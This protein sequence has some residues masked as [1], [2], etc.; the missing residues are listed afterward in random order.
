MQLDIG[1]DNG[2]GPTLNVTEASIISTCT[3]GAHPTCSIHSGEQTDS[4]AYE[5][6]Q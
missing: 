2:A 5:P 4:T 1:T 6:N 3:P